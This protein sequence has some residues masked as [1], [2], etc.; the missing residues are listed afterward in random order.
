MPKNSNFKNPKPIEIAKETPISSTK[1]KKPIS[2]TDEIFGGKKRKKLENQEK[3]N[4]NAVRPVMEP[5]KVKKSKEKSSR[6][7]KDDVLSEVPRK[8]RKKTGDGFTVYNGRRVG[9]WEV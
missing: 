5:K 9:Y 8:P 4:G 7:T 3:T 2:E 6:K 1:S